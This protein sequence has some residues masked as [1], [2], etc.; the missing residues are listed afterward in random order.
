MRIVVS[1]HQF[2]L[3]YVCIC[4]YPITSKKK[5]N[6]NI[7]NPIVKYQ[8]TEEEKVGKERIKKNMLYAKK[9]IYQKREKMYIYSE[10]Q[11]IST[12]KHIDGY[13]KIFCNTV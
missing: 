5:S 6:A 9:N 12:S 7:L 2:V 4:A 10:S 13:K 3:P 11:S 8:A 1:G